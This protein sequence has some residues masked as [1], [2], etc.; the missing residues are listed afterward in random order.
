MALPLGEEAL[1]RL[2]PESL[3]P[4]VRRPVEIVFTD[5]TA[6]LLSA[7]LRNGTWHLRA[8]RLF[9]RVPPDVLEAISKFLQGKRDEGGVLRRF[10][11]EHR[12]LIRQRLE[13]AAPRRELQSLGEHHDLAAVLAGLIERHFPALEPPR[14]GW[15]KWRRKGRTVRLGSY[16]PRQHLIYINPRLDRRTVPAY[17]V[18]FLIYHE[19]CHAYLSRTEG[20]KAGVRHGPEFKS[21][22]E[23]HPCY[24]IAVAWEKKNLNRI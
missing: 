8:H 23:R 19:L 4:L 17:F 12:P 18:E 10:V 1:A 15:G 6:S 7:R 24:E 13:R 11:E 3:F 2:S 21:L 16:F 14:I 5:N 22:E 9:G 20:E